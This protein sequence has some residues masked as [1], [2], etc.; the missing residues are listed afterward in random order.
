MHP[1]QKKG[2]IP[3]E[4]G[5][6]ASTALYQMNQGSVKVSGYDIP[7]D[8]GVAILDK[9]LEVSEANGQSLIRA[10][11]LSVNPGIGGNIDYYA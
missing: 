4:I 8:V 3:M 2:G 5:A 11:E 6:L 1:V 7:S 9:Q 10:M